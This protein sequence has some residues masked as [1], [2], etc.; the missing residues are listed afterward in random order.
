MS[1]K[2]VLI[3]TFFVLIF[4]I[5]CSE[6]EVK[7]PLEEVGMVGIMAFDYIDED[8]TKLTVAIPQYSPEAKRN[9]QIFS[10]KTDLVSKGIVKIE[11]LSD[12]K[13]ILNQLRVVLINEE[14]AQKGNV[15]KVIQHLYRNAEV[16]NKVLIAI[17]K[18]NAEEML[19]GKY[20]DKPNINFY[21]NDLLLPSINTAF[22]P[23]TN[24]H[25]FIYTITNPVFDPIIP[26]IEKIDDKIEIKG[27]ALFKNRHMLEMIT[28]EDALIIQAIQGRKKL[29]PLLIEMNQGYN[30][31]KVM[32]DLIESNVKFESNKSVDSPKLTISLKIKGTLS[33][34]KGKREHE[35]N[36]PKSIAILEKDINEQVE[37]DIKKFIEKINDLEIDPIGLS[38]NF[39]M[40][41]KGKWNKKLTKETLA[42]L[43]VVVRVDTSIISTGTL[44]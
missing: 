23:N 28:P 39:R 24:I 31:E 38:E 12:K 22:N 8:T 34:Y 19:K 33:E 21:L 1:R 27:V 44:K 25:G 17:V 20:L 30:K 16:G 37:K 11:K 4:L 6:K 9:T 5:G 3:F 13:V 7:V 18:G 15:Q 43:Q 36:T 14:Y 26:V 2:L 10:V 40:Y 32:L 29:A 35:L 41:H 42:K